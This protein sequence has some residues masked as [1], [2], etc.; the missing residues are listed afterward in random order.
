[1]KTPWFDRTS[2][3]LGFRFWGL[4]IPLIL[5][6]ISVALLGLVDTAVSGHLPGAHY[7]GG[8]ALGGSVFSFLYWGFNFL[9]MGTSGLA[10]QA[11]GR[12]DPASIRKTLA[13]ALLLAG[14]CAAVLLLLQ[15]PI[16]DLALHLFAPSAAVAEQTR[17]YFSV[18]IWATPAALANFV[19]LG[20]FIGLQKGRAALYLLLTVNGVNT[21]L[22]IW[23]VIGLGWGVEGVAAASV[24][25]ELAGSLLALFLV[26]TVL[27]RYPG[28]WRMADLMDPA[29]L[30]KLFHTH[31]HLFVRTMA[32]LSV[33][34][35][36][37]AQSA[38]MGDTVIAA[39][40]VVM[41]FYLLASFALDG[42][43][44]AAEALVGE[45]VGAS[46][47]SYL[48]RVVKLSLVWGMV[49]ALLFSAGYLLAG[50]HLY[51][52]M[53][54]LPDVRRLLAELLPWAMVL[55]LVSFVGFLMDGIFTGATWTRDMRNTV[56]ISSG[57]VFLPIWYLTLPMAVHGLW[58]SFV[59]FNL[60]RG[61]SLGAVF[62]WRIRNSAALTG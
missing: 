60:A 47:R 25:G 61:A 32:L 33:F 53:T 11:V 2:P 27:P 48:L 29:S 43:A 26:R 13:Q 3:Q 12:N 5:S 9:R 55:P 1:M 6:N 17:L 38:R 4:A 31:H 28:Q 19:M 7:L 14:F 22:D 42:L 58:L 50:H 46:N 52:L 59:L 49:V 16:I 20:W 56:L 57:L 44:N 35:F 8:V 62:W 45:A 41:N 40:A 51:A 39:T 15:Q 18:R 23:L 36:V 34:A 37:N 54:D 21:L 30:K 10:A 24:A